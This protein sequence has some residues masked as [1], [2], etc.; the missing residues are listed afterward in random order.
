[1]EVVEK[2]GRNLKEYALHS[3]RIGSAST[4]AAGG[5]VSERVIQRERR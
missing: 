1:R 5:D 3:L 4:L 2:S